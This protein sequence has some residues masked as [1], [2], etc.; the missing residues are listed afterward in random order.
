MS[1]A[2]DDNRLPTRRP[3]RFRR[4]ARPRAID[5]RLPTILACIAALRLGVKPHPRKSG[6][7]LLRPRWCKTL[8]NPAEEW[9][10]LTVSGIAGVEA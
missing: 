4:H 6:Q 1:R 5:S 8:D 9:Y 10:A 7:T 3:T 2:A